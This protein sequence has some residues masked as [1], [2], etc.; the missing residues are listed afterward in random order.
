M[1][2]RKPAR[3]TS[4]GPEQLKIVHAAFDSAWEVVKVDYGVDPVS[5]EVGRHRLANAVLK[6][7]KDGVQETNALKTAGIELMKRWV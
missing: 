7:F 2:D 4:L 1:T 3:I 5:I 6:A